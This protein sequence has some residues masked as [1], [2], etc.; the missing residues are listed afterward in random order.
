MKILGATTGYNQL[1]DIY[2]VA[3]N[4]AVIQA[5]A[6]AFSGDWI[7][8]RPSISLGFQS[9]WDLGFATSTGETILDGKLQI[10]NGALLVR[11]GKLAVD[12]LQ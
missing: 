11:T 2:A 3:A 6:V 4:N 8:N 7:L 12:G 1:A 10:Q 9:G 5:R